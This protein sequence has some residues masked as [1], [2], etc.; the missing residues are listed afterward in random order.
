MRTLTIELPEN[1][2]LATGQSREEF[3]RDAKYLLA[4]KL[5]ELGRLSSGKASELAG[6]NH[7]DFLIAMGRQ[8]V[9]VT[10]LD[11]SAAEREFADG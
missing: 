11:E 7:V 6:M 9:A 1:L 2:L 8:R 10:D 3:V 5:F 4:A